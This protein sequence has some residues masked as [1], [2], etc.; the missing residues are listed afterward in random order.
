M[1]LSPLQTT[2]YGDISCFSPGAILSV[3]RKPEGKAAHLL[4]YSFEGKKKLQFLF[5]VISTPFNTWN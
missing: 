1:K 3:I 5:R 4:S 2:K